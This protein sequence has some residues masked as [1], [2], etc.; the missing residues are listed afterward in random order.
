MAA[1][2]ALRI[3]AE[4]FAATRSGMPV[5]ALESAVITHGLPRAAALEAVERQWR[6]CETAG[7]V[8]AVVAVIGWRSGLLAGF[9]ASS[10]GLRLPVRADSLAE[11]AELLRRHWE[12]GGAGVVVSQPLPG[13]LAIPLDELTAE[14]PGAER[15]SDRTPAE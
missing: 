7:A 5:V 3:A 1:V 6:S 12:L 11:L 2:S 14:P 10:V 4:V 9:L 8:P 13:D 15:G